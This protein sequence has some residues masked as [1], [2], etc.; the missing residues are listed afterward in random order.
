MHDGI[1]TLMSDHRRCEE[2]LAQ[3]RA[4]SSPDPEVVHQVIVEVCV[5]DVTESQVLYPLVEERLP[6]GNRLATD[7]LNQHVRIANI[8][9][10]L[11]RR[12]PDEPRRRLLLDSLV[13]DCRQHFAVEEVSL[14][15]PLRRLLAPEELARLD[16]DLTRARINAPALPHPHAPRFAVGTHVAAATLRPLDR[17]R[18]GLRRR[19]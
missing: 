15:A 10:E 2:L 17:L 7:T 11:D 18:A 5:H 9:V 1:E 14:L 4:Q 8:L 6:E 16:R 19:R 13:E 3:I 12:H